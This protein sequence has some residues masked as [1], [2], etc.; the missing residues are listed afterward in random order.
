[1]QKIIIVGGGSSGWLAAA[2]LVKYFPNK[3]IIVLESD[4]IPIIGVGESTTATFREFININLGIDDKEFMPGVDAVYKM[5]VKFNDFYYENDEGFH[6]PFVSAYTEGL[7][8]FMEESWEIIKYFNK[9]I[10]RQD[11]VKFLVSTYSLFNKN[12]ISINKNLQFDNYNPNY[13]LGYHLDA[14]KLGAWLKNK[15]CIPRGV[16][17]LIGEVVN[18]VVSEKGIEKLQTSI[19]E[20]EADLYIDCTGFKKVLISSL[21][22]VEY[23][24]LSHKLPNN[25][26]WAVPTKYSDIYKQMTPYTNCTALKNGWA[27]Y[28]PIWTRI[29]NGYAYSDKYISDDEALVEFKEYLCSDK[30]FR[31]LETNEVENLPFFKLNMSAGFCKESFVKNVCAI[32]LSSGFLEPL[33]GTGLYFVTDSVL[34]LIKMLSREKINQFNKDSFNMHMQY[35]WSDWADI[36]STFYTYSVRE[37]SDYWK[38]ITSKTFD[39]RILDPNFYSASYGGLKEYAETS[40]Y[41]HGFSR[42]KSAGFNRANDFI[43]IGYDMSMNVDGPQ[44]DKLKFHNGIDFDS[45]SKKYLETMKLNYNRWSTEAAKEPYMYDFLKNNIY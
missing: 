12:K 32:G 24:D 38:D 1:M 13:M 10:K 37:D 8:P 14:N 23:V 11:F 41:S 29:G 39:K 28:T 19:G 44:I 42:T 5:S 15:Y 34:L 7:E 22:E 21:K 35:K 18:V 43:S 33:E 6:Y 3:E 27:W 36:L 4:K 20:L 26:A 31:K 9:E 2:G 45:L 17:H 25:K 16:K 30:N 40:I